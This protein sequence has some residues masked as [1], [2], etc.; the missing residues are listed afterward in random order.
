M[1]TKITSS[2]AVIVSPLL[3]RR[4]QAT[5]ILDF[6]R[7]GGMMIK[8]PYEDMF[9]HI[10]GQLFDVLSQSGRGEMVDKSAISAALRQRLFIVKIHVPQNHSTNTSRLNCV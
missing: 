6:E 10:F 5:V 9:C 4:L 7:D 2:V 8:T 3:G 1:E